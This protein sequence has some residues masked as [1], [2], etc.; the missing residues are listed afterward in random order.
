MC[1]STALSTSPLCMYYTRTSLLVREVPGQRRGINERLQFFDLLAFT[2]LST[3]VSTG[4]VLASPFR[5]SPLQHHRFLSLCLDAS[6]Q[7]FLHTTQWG[8]A[9]VFQIGLRN[10]LTPLMAI[11]ILTLWAIWIRWCQKISPCY[12][13]T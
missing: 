5:A 2:T 1:T 6:P 13:V 8:A 3:E 7:T 4:E 10:L 12:I 11:H 9:K